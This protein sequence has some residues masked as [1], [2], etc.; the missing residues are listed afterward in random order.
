VSTTQIAVQL[1]S[2]RH[3][4]KEDMLGALGHVAEIGYRAVEFAGYGSATV[5]EIRRRLDDLGVRAVSAH[6]PFDR[7]TTEI[8]RV[9][10]EMTALGCAHAVVPW[11]A[12]E[13][14]GAERVPELGDRFNAWGARC[15]EAGIRFGYHNHDFELEPAGDGLLLDRMIAAT[16]PALVDFQI[17]FYFTAAAGVDGAALIRRL[18]G[19]V[20]TL[21]MKDL[22]PGPDLNNLAVGSGVIDWD[23]ILAATK[24]A[25]TE[26][27]IVEQESQ[28]L[29][30]AG[31]L[32]YLQ[33]KLGER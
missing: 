14:R 10:E 26:W 25:G 30:L 3:L 15:R 2:V 23:P 11:L 31:S 17:D 28:P 24:E 16:D 8:D 18:A 13:W 29:D 1:Y 22:A 27:Y 33:R 32:R 21:H 19:R 9:L 6:V 5:P 20:P 7:F 12:P 4:A